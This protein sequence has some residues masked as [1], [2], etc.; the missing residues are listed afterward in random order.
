MTRE[1]KEM[2]EK[3]IGE[4]RGKEESIGKVITK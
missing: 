1:R 4:E 2:R 3:G